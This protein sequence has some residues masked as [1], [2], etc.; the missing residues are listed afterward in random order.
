MSTMSNVKSYG[1]I[2]NT[3][4]FNRRTG[5]L[6]KK[7]S[8]KQLVNRGHGVTNP[9]KTFFVI[10]LTLS[11]VI[12][13]LLRGVMGKKTQENQTFLKSALTLGILRIKCGKLTPGLY[14][15][16]LHKTVD[17]VER[18]INACTSSQF[19]KIIT[20]VLEKMSK[21]NFCHY[22]HYCTRVFLEMESYNLDERRK[23]RTTTG[24]RYW[25]RRRLHPLK[26]QSQT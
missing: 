18:I 9:V 22:C 25:W 17:C 8:G 12:L 14:S 10:V 20:L 19:F 5:Y 23:L 15:M 6:L 24:S 11:S 13:T 21:R 7:V 16:T 26:V 1:P 2:R 3:F 4:E